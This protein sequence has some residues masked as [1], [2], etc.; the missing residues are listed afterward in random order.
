MARIFITGS[1]DGLGR[2]AARTL[3]NQGHEVFLHA[4]TR[5]RATALAELA[6]AA[7]IVV[8]DLSSAVETHA[9]AAQVNTIGRMDA[10]IHNAGIYLEPIT[11]A[12]EAHD[13]GFQ[14]R[15][16]NRLAEV[17]GLGLAAVAG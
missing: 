16:L 6:D 3:I 8:G 2:A 7:G 17:T 11:P 9:L 15:L 4:R 10:V 1:A 12:A 5:G 13:A 14:D